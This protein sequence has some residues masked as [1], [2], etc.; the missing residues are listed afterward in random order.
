MSLGT[1]CNRPDPA[2]VVS[3]RLD[4]IRKEAKKSMAIYVE[5]KVD[6]N[7]WLKQ[8]FTLLNSGSDVNLVSAMAAKEWD[9]KLKMRMFF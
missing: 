6:I 4:V 5:T 1:L 8:V 7:T 9:W 3:L 2:I